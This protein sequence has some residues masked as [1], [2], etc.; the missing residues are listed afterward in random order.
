MA[1]NYPS[2][3]DTSTQQPTIAASDEMDDSGKEHDVVHT[4]H[5]GAIIALE[6]K[7]GTGDSNATANAVLMGTGSGTSEWDTSPTFKGA[8][9]VGEDDT[10][11]DVIFYGA[12]A[13]SKLFWDESADTLF[14]ENSQIKIQ[15]DSG[16]AIFQLRSAHDTEATTPLIE[17]LKEDGSL[18]SP[19]A[20]DDDA[21]L[22][23]MD[24]YGYDGD[25]YALGARIQALVNGTPGDG[26]MPTE[27]LFST[28]ADGSASP[29][30]RYRIGPEGIHVFGYDHS[31]YLNI[32]Q[33]AAGTTGQIRWTYN[34]DDTALYAT[35]GIVYDDRATDGWHLNVGYPITIDGKAGTNA[36]IQFRTN[37]THVAQFDTDGALKITSSTAKTPDSSWSGQFQISAGTGSSYTGGIA[38]DNTAMWVGHNSGSRELY[39]ATNE[40]ARLKIAADGEVMLPNVPAFRAYK[41]GSSTV[42]TTGAAIWVCDT[43]IFDNGGNFN[44]TNGKFYAPVDGYYFFTWHMFMHTGYDN[45]TDTYWGFVATG[46]NA[47][48]NHGDNGVDGG[49]SISALFHLDAGD[50]CYPYISSGSKTLTSYTS[51]KYNAFNGYLVG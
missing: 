8:V 7:L 6:T 47:W 37:G 34:Q 38:I 31:T 45:D 36:P 24:F 22:G 49:Q 20:V 40:T 15:K 42:S 9:T 25:S 46:D 32:R 14:A 44:T 4:N 23:R 39:L 51:A 30:Q 28:S 10:G 18:A 43:E 19:A 5:S 2:S 27:L 26:D 17:F 13:S 3:L 50:V 33:G 16:N 29:T 12:T 1:T 48:F 21:S 35:M 41:S 11:H